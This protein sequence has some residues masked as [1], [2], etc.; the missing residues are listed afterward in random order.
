MLETLSR[1]LE[2]FFWSEPLAVDSDFTAEDPLALDYLGQQVGLWLFPGFTTRTSRAQYYAVVLY[3]LH[4]ADKAVHLYGYPGDDQT[5][6]RLFERW[7]RFWSLATLEYRNGQLVRGDEDA[8]RGVRGATRAWFPGNKPLPLDFPLISRQSELGGLGAYLSSLREYGLVFPGSLRVTPAANPILDVFWKE[9]GERNTT[10]RYEEYALAALDLEKNRI[11]RSHGRLTL[12]GL[13]LRSR[14]SSLVHLKRREQ[15]DRLWS[16]LFLAARDG[17]TLALAERLIEA[18]REGITDSE[19]ILRGLVEGK[20]GGLSPELHRLVE[21]GLAF[22]RFARELLSRFDRIYGHV[23]LH[24]WVADIEETAIAG[25]PESE[26][27]VLRS[28]C[29]EVFN[30]AEV[31]RFRKLQYHGPQIISLLSKLASAD[32]RESLDLLLRFHRGVQYSRRGGGSW[33]REEQ[34]KIVMQVAGYNGYKADADFPSLKLNV[35]LQM[36]EDLGRL[37]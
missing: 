1:P 35:V 29:L 37:E 3:G 8:M 24:G 34:G 36:L 12:G 21:V 5:R 16:A 15:Q 31:T 26:S 23:D 4:L 19:T 32:S 14:L 11:A 2:S 25:F 30:A 20:W 9:T 6:T 22:G 7:E 10:D 13:G 33:L 27:Q 17:S 18:Y 28:L